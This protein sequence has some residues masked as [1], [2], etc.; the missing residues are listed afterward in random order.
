MISPNIQNILIIIIEEDVERMWRINRR[1]VDSFEIYLDR[2]KSTSI[3]IDRL[4]I[5][6]LYIYASICLLSNI[7]KILSDL[8][9]SIQRGREFKAFDGVRT[10]ALRR[11]PC[12]HRDSVNEGRRHVSDGSSIQAY[13]RHLQEFHGGYVCP[14]CSYDRTGVRQIRG[15]DERIYAERDDFLKGS[16]VGSYPDRHGRKATR[17]GKEEKTEE[18]ICPCCYSWECFCPHHSTGMAMASLDFMVSADVCRSGD[19]C[20]LYRHLRGAVF[21][22]LLTRF[23]LGKWIGSMSVKD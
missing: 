1:G 9:R 16:Q 6:V 17:E 3:S 11:R 18:S 2:I 21:S 13:V 23:G 10:P 5:S 15:R 14:I 20:C 12:P 7:L 19:R 4:F 8:Y 22:K